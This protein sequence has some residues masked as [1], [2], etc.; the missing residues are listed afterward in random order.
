M[1]SLKWPRMVSSYR[2]VTSRSLPAAH[3]PVTW[4]LYASNNKRTWRMIDEQDDGGVPMARDTPSEL[5]TD[6]RSLSED[7]SFR[8]A[9]LA[10]L[11]ATG[12]SL[13]WLTIGSAWIA[14]GS[15]TCVDSAP[16]LCNNW[17]YCQRCCHDSSW[18]EDT[19]A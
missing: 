2:I 16:E 4:Q 9:F 1:V 8:Q 5:I 14:R 13:G 18:S 15:E 11:I 6:L 3:D 17:S 10:E 19:V 12:I 7:A